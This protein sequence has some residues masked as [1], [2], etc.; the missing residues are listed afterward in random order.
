VDGV[1]H[2]AAAM[3]WPRYFDRIL[4]DAPCSSERH[5]MHGASGA[6]WSTARLKRD[7]NLQLNLL[8]VAV[9]RLNPNGG[10]LVYSTCSIAPVENDAVISK[11]LSHPDYGAGL[12]LQDPLAEL[13]GEQIWS[14]LAGVERTRCGAI[15]LPDNS[16]FGPLYWAVLVR[17]TDGADSDGAAH[18][19]SDDESSDSSGSR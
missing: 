8:R 16:R 5:V 7:A 15:M 13:G 6:D 4:L 2:R 18:P 14:I 10:R 9:R 3:H 17:Q 12:T 11:L 19:S 1:D